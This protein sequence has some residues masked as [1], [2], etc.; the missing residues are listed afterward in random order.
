MGLGQALAVLRVG[1]VEALPD[2]D[3]PQGGGEG[4][5]AVRVVFGG[6]CSPSG[7]K[8]YRGMPSSSLS[9]SAR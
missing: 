8:A 4:G 2:L 9:G 5:V 3:G 6:G 7:W 1:P